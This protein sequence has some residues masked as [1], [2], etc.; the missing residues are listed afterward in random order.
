M[1]NPERG[2]AY[3]EAISTAVR[4]GPAVIPSGKGP[5]P[6]ADVAVPPRQI[7]RT[8]L[9]D[10][11]YIKLK[12]EFMMSTVSREDS[13]I[14]RNKHR[15]QTYLPGAIRP[16]VLSD[17]ATA[18]ADRRDIDYLTASDYLGQNW[19]GVGECITDER[20][21]C[22]R[23]SRKKVALMQHELSPQVLIRTF[24]K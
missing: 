8:V 19:G 22:S 5:S 10:L 7:P 24:H 9:S 12:T 16:V 15:A 14:R 11:H 3:L 4:D 2:F 1:R 18:P 21:W 17:R 13:F 23:D 20:A 6:L